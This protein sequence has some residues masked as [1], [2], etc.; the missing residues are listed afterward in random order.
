VT[1]V[2][3]SLTE[4]DSA[5]MKTDMGVSS[6]MDT[7]ILLQNLEG[8]GERNRGLYILKS[9]G[10]AHSNQIREFALTDQGIELREIY[11]GPEGVLTGS[12]RA[13]QE[14]KEKAA[15]QVRRE[16]IERKQRELERK[17]QALEAQILSLRAQFE[18]E[19]EELEKEI[20]QDTRREQVLV[21]DQTDLANMRWA[22]SASRTRRSRN[23]EGG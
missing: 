11:L 22:A 10:M 17:R 3:N 2:F 18:S 21:D 15:A 14:A 5:E 23:G 19:A 16:V 1:S 7:W 8:N 4:G 9:R 6:L 20:S 12:A 13:A